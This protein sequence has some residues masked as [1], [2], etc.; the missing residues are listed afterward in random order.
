MVIIMYTYLPTR[1]VSAAGDSMEQENYY[2]NYQ[3]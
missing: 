2:M 3:V 1:K